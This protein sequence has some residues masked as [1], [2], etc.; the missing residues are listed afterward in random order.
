MK[1][2]YFLLFAILFLGKKSFAQD[3]W[4]GSGESNVS[5]R[6]IIAESNGGL[7]IGDSFIAISSSSAVDIARWSNGKY[8][9]PQW[10]PPGN[11]YTGAT[12]VST[13]VVYNDTLYVV[14]IFKLPDPM[15]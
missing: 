9:G 2:I 6:A 12:T 3:S 14:I 1:K 5:V 13:L 4:N 15:R 11:D 10:N 7:Y 8:D